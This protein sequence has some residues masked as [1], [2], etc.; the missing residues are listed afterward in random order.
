M[1]LQ[2]TLSP[3]HTLTTNLRRARG[4][5]LVLV[6]LAML[7]PHVRAQKTCCAD[8]SKCGAS[9][10][11]ASAVKLDAKA[12]TRS[13]TQ[14][15]KRMVTIPYS[16]KELLA[17]GP[18]APYSDYNLNEIAF[19][20]GGLGAGSISL[21]GWGQLRDWEIYNHPSKGYTAPNTFF[22]LRVQQPG[23]APLTKIIQGP[24]R[25]SLNSGGGASVSGG[26][27]GG[28]PRFKSVTFTGE[29]PMATLKFNDPTMPVEVRLEAFSPFIP[30]D[31][32]NS[33][34]PVAVFR[35]MIKNTSKKPVDAVL[36]GTLANLVG[37]GDGRTNEAG[38]DGVSGILMSNPKQAAGSATAGTMAL[39]TSWKDTVVWP[40]FGPGDFQKFWQHIAADNPLSELPNAK[41][42][43]TGS[44]GAKVTLRPGESVTIPFYIAWHFSA[45]GS[46]RVYYATQ[47]KDAWDVAVYA[48]KNEEML[49]SE[50]KRFHDTLFASSLPNYI[51]DAVS[52]QL[53]T[54]KTTTC[55]RLEDGTFYGYEG[56]GDG[57]GCC[58][59][60][61]THVW[62]YAQAL[63]Y[64][65]PPMQRSMSS[66]HFA[67]DL[68]DDGFMTFRMPLPLGVKGDR[69]YHAAADGQMGIVTQVYRDWLICGD[70]EWLART[71]PSA[72][73]ALEFA[74]KYWDADKDG[75][76]EGM[77]HNTYDIEFHG[78]NTMMGSLYLAALEAGARLA[79]EM[80]EPV[81]AKEYREIA[82]KGSAWTDKNLFNGEYYIQ[83]VNPKA[84]D[85][86]PEPQRGM[87][88]GAGTDT[89]FK[90]WPR[91]QY[92]TGCLSDQL[93]GQWY[94][95]MLGFGPLYNPTNVKNAL[96]SVFN[97]NWKPDTSVVYDFARP[98]V[99]NNEPGLIICTWPKGGRPGQAFWYSDEV[100]PGIEYQVAGNLIYEGM[101]D[102]GL[103][104]AKGLRSRFTGDQRNPWNEFECGHH[105]ARSMAS[106]SLLLALS[107]FSYSAPEQRIGFAPKI[108][109]RNFQS[110]FS[111]GSGWGNYS[112][113]LGSKSQ[114]S[115]TIQHGSLNVKTLTTAIRAGRI[116]A[117]LDGNKVATHTEKGETGAAVIFGQPVR[118]KEGQTLKVSLQ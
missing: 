38:H 100:W 28:L 63:P 26:I 11:T 91:S 49:Y 83:R 6:L 114:I 42:G 113:K 40:T 104:I 110:F 103:A 90:D 66:A 31:D 12:E 18:Q 68:Q 85:L 16:K 101:V 22:I 54:L 51:L 84:R 106:Y 75:I 27:G 93:I 89:V 13:Q 108:N 46:G 39:A 15:V 17:R 65:F 25:G 24:I 118:V 53:S 86:W 96:Q 60:S 43:S 64:L 8:P 87:S 34:L 33:S 59:G 73:K 55:M 30:L 45:T 29:Y 107:G 81:K 97:Y 70:R 78:P 112:Q 5:M 52:S 88:V 94:A 2:S 58:G 9:A 36:F 57:G 98:Y 1:S 117:T 37:E 61:C 115:L 56:C 20:L 47:W 23:Q 4:Y 48:A 95:D 21:G 80:G 116:T 105:Y 3:S 41:G 69:G 76:M 74:W 67:N 109:Q 44:V 50:T 7:A 72:K 19:P 32:R 111:V 82:A 102:E 62:N 92:G 77:Q 14:M 35:Y 79:E 71:W 10:T 99:V